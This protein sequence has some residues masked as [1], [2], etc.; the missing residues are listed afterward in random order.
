MIE[1]QLEDSYLVA[2]YNPRRLVIARG[3]GCCLFDT[4]GKRY[5]DFSTGIGV[6]A[7]G[8]GHPRL[9]EAA[10][11]QMERCFQTSNLHTHRYQGLLARKLAEW[12]GLHKVFFSNSG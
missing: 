10:R 8:Y 11:D 9:L 2:T 4:D 5:L 7:L 12:S 3:D 6:N 1:H